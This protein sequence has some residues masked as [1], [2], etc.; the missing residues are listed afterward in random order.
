MCFFA[1]QKFFKIQE[2]VQKSKFQLAQSPLQKL[3][4]STYEVQ[5]VSK[6]NSGAYGPRSAGQYTLQGCYFFFELLNFEEFLNCKKHT[7]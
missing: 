5:K 4:M 6:Q 1:I 7:E 2:A 3:D